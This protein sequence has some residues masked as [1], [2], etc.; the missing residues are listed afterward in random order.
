MRKC[1]V[2]DGYKETGA[3]RVRFCSD[4]IS[5]ALY[6]ALFGLSIFCYMLL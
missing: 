5:I 3:G 4:L 6:I 1:D 2:F